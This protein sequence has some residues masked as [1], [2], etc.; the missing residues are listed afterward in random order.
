[1]SYLK[2]DAKDAIQMQKIMTL[3]QL[4]GQLAKRQSVF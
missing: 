4:I 3:H 2:I 1:M